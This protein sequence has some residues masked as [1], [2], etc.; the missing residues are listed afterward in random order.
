VFHV[1]RT[2]TELNVLFWHVLVIY[3]FKD[4]SLKTV[5]VR[6]LCYIRNYGLSTE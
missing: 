6:I 4:E 3:A 5:N 2:E 1:C